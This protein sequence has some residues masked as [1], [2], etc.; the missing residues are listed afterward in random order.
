M[1]QEITIEEVYK[2]PDNTY[3][4][5]DIRDDVLVSYGMIP[6]AIHIKLEDLQNKIGNK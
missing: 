1:M 5:I 6:D 3:R 2:L 4:L